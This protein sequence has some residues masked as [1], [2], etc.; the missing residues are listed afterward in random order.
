MGDPRVR[1]YLVWARFPFVRLEQTPGGTA[2]FF[3][4][5]RYTDGPSSGA[6]QGIRV[7]LD[8]D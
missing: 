4:D 8:N 3:G 5:A 7:I 6:L 2:V 1:D